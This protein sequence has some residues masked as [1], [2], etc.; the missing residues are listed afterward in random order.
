MDNVFKLDVLYFNND[1]RELVTLKVEEARDMEALVSRIF[2]DDMTKIIQFVVPNRHEDQDCREFCPYFRFILIEYNN[3]LPINY[4]LESMMKQA[5]IDEF[6]PRC[7][8]ALV[9]GVC[10]AIDLTRL[11]SVP[12][13]FQMY[14]LNEIFSTPVD[15]INI[16]G[17]LPYELLMR[18]LLYCRHPCA[19]LIEEDMKN[20]GILGQCTS[21]R[22]RRHVDK[23]FY[24]NSSLRYQV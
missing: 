10:C 5:G 24:W 20:W 19:V 13:I 3:R 4:K 23:V 9:F 7:R 12:F 15:N 6:S 1:D 14:H 8:G 17:N 21:L 16:Q 11:T 18:I 22:W 2:G